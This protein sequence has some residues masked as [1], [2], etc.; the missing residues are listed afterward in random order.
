MVRGDSAATTG[1]PGNPP[2]FLQIIET[3]LVESDGFVSFGLGDLYSSVAVVPE[4]Q[5]AIF[6]NFRLEGSNE[7]GGGTP[8]CDFDGM[9]G[10]N[11]DDINM[12]SA[13]IASGNNNL[14]FDL[15]GDDLV[16]LDDIEDPDDGWLRLAGEENLGAG[17]SYLVGDADLNGFVDGQDFIRW[18][19]NKFTPNTN[20]SDGNFN[21]DGFVDGQDFV[22]WN[23]NKFQDSFPAPATV[24]EPASVT[25]LAMVALLAG[26]RRRVS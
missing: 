11:E 5:F 9:N 21:G 4:D 6:D 14:D 7:P 16:N 2:E 25:L 13:E 18:N 22:R 10:C 23:G 24:P 19:G 8:S 1:N 20:W 26:V 3:E 15:T 17:L 12:L